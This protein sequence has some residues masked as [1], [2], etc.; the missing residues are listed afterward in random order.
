MKKIK[1]F[2]VQYFT[3]PENIKPYEKGWLYRAVVTYIPVIFEN[4]LQ[5]EKNN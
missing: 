3:F 5:L 4:A 2:S 1:H